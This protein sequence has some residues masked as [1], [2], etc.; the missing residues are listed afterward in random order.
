M[1]L[2]LGCN[3]WRTKQWIEDSLFDPHALIPYICRFFQNYTLLA[4]RM[5]FLIQVP[6][7]TMYLIEDK[8]S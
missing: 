3:V 8:L 7:Q 5:Y 1:K 6:S 2:H 4:Y